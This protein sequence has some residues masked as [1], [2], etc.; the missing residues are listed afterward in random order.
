[1]DSLSLLVL[2]FSTHT[3]LIG[4]FEYLGEVVGQLGVNNIEEI[5]SGRAPVVWVHGGKVRHDDRVLLHLGP[6]RLDR[7]LIVMGY[8]D[9][10]HLVLHEELLPSGE[11]VLEE[12][13]VDG[14]LRGQV[15][16]NCDE[17]NLD[18]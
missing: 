1:M 9:V 15:A 7:K 17:I 16:L 10:A 11:D 5:F 2:T 8:M 3:L 12:I 13:M 6:E 14:C 18:D 4:V